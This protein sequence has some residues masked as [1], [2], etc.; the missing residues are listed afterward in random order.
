[1]HINVR[2]YIINNV[3]LLHVLANLVVISERCLTNDGYHNILQMF[4][5]QGTT[6][7]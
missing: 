5:D 4:K 2:K 6:K 1:M 7:P 3:F